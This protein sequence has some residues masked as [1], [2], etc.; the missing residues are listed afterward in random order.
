MSAEPFLYS[1][2]YCAILYH[3]SLSASAKA[4]AKH[5]SGTQSLCCKF[6]L[7]I[8]CDQGQEARRVSGDGCLS[9]SGTRWAFRIRIINT[10]KT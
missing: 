9:D 1:F 8:Y 4:E 3:V 7:T 2:V 6:F 5:I 10:N